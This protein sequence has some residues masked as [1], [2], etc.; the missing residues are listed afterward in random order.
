MN[1]PPRPTRAEIDLSALV[2]NLRQLRTCCSQGEG[3][4]AVV[5]ADAYGH[6]A[7]EA[8]RAL[9]AEQVEYFGVALLEEALVLRAAG[10][11]SPILVLGGCYPGQEEAFLAWKLTPAVFSMADLRRLADYGSGAGKSFPVHLKCDTGMGRV[12]FLPHELPELLELMPQLVGVEIAGLMSHLACAD[13]PGSQATAAQIK[14][15]QDLLAAFR[16]AGI[17]PGFVHLSNSAGL[18]AWE[19]PGCNLVRPGIA[20]YGGAPLGEPSSGLDLRPVMTFETRIAQLRTLGAGQGVSYGH[21][22]R[23]ARQTRVATLPVGYADGYNRLLSNRGEVLIR[24]E[25]APVVGRVCMDWIMVDVT[26]IEDAQIGDRV[27]LLGRDGQESITAGDWARWLDTIDYEVFC[28]I[29][30]RVPRC[31]VNAPSG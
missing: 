11:Q 1:I 14:N 7:V 21:I 20:L 24:G 12:G 23:T 19:I 8:S 10:I 13:L 2:H 17:D 28:R 29:G 22:Y 16:A 30:P 9:E 3:V 27:V 6:G 25:R 5:K 26:D 31:Y 18:V 15:F 4:L